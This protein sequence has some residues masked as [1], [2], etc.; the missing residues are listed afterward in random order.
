MHKV[1]QSAWMSFL[2]HQRKCTAMWLPNNNFLLMSNRSRYIIN[3]D[4]PAFVIHPRQKNN[5]E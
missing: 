5:E 2:G 3:T 1:I 4:I